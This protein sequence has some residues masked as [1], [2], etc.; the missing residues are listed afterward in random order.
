MAEHTYLR[1]TQPVNIKHHAYSS[2]VDTVNCQNMLAGARA[3]MA[4]VSIGAVT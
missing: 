1:A 2:M 4:L 3:Y